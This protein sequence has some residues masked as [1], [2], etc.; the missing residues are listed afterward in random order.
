MMHDLRPPS[1]S[2]VLRYA[3]IGAAAAIVD[4]HLD[5]LEGVPCEIVGMADVDAERGATKAAKVGCAFFVD[6]HDLLS[7][8]RPDAVVICTPHPLHAEQTLDALSSGAHVLVEKPMAVEVADADAM[9]A[10][11]ERTRRVLAVNFQERFRAA[12]QYARDFIARGELGPLLRVLSVEPWLRTAAYYRSA[13]WRG[14]WKGE[15]GGV[16]MNQA[17]HTLD[18]L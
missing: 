11:A 14:T 5:G 4:A 7:V 16:L 13:S 2:P 3:F 8:V 10:T 15:G 12:V 17:P 18:V 9:I 1:D 6:H